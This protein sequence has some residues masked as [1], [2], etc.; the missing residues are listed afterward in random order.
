MNIR[1]LLS[2]D[3]LHMLG[4]VLH[5]FS[6]LLVKQ[7]YSIFWRGIY[8]WVTGSGASTFNIQK[9]IYHS[10]TLWRVIIHF[11]TFS[12]SAR[13]PAL[14]L[15]ETFTTFGEVKDFCFEI[16][17]RIILKWESI[18]NEGSKH[19]Q[20][21]GQ[22]PA[23]DSSQTLGLGRVGGDG[24]EDVDQ[25]EE[26]S[27]EERHPAGDDVRWDHETYPGDHNKQTWAEWVL[28]QHQQDSVFIFCSIECSWL[29]TSVIRDRYLGIHIYLTVD[30]TW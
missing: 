15:C 30:N 16:I 29:G 19:E 20:Q 1:S 24:V 26:E 23:L 25:D 14:T 5:W 8:Y 13:H 28:P 3:Y 9:I 18:T 4:S 21:A 10:L 17:N 22:H 27:D 7:Y 11:K 12:N 2:F 6:F